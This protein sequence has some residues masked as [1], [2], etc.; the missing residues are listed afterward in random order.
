MKVINFG[1]INIDHVYEVAHFVRPGETLRSDSY[2]IFS[3]GKGANQSLSLARAG[4]KVLHAGKIGV[5]GQWL[6]EKLQESGVDIS[7]IETTD[8][9]T[10]H[11]LIQVNTQ[12]ENAII[13]HGGANETVTDDDIERVL[14]RAEQGDCL[15][16]QNEINSVAKIIQKAREIGLLIIFNPAP[17]SEAV[18]DYPLGLVDVFIINEVEGQAL[19]QQNDPETIVAYMQRLYPQSRTVLTL[20]T[21]GVVYGDKDKVISLPAIEV[22]AVDTTGAGDT[23][24]GYFVAEMISGSQIEQCLKMGVKASALCVTRKGAGDSIPLRKEVDGFNV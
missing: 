19:T 14:S 15:L 23:F 20:G 6:K 21:K 22:E 5:D 17:M 13:I 8:T 16:V 12:G 1:S 2:S 3:G 7:L 24:I 11:A 4:A 9:P 10:G 18:N